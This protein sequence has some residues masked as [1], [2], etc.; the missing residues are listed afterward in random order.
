MHPIRLDGH[1]AYERK[2]G[3]ITKQGK[4]THDQRGL[5]TSEREAEL[6]LPNLGSV[7]KVVSVN[8]TEAELARKERGLITKQGKRTHNRRGFITKKGS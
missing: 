7:T 5:I 1:D 2:K 3:L 8:S 4:R 6:G